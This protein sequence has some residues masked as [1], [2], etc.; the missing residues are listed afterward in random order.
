MNEVQSAVTVL[1][2]RARSTR[3][4]FAKYEQ[5]TVGHEWGAAELMA[6]FVADVGDLSRLVMA[7][8]GHRVIEDHEA[9]LEHELADCLW[10]V[11]VIADALGIDLGPAFVRTMDELETSLNR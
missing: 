10:S 5:A 6:G 8:Q 2:E 11:L 1:T 3:A 7:S 9:K 4:A